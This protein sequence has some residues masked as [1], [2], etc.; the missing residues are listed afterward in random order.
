MEES[1]NSKECMTLPQRPPTLAMHDN[2]HAITKLKPKIRIVHIF[3][4][5]IIKTDPANF[6]ELVQRLT[7]KP[8]K[9]TAAKKK[10]I[11]V[12]INGEALPRCKRFEVVGSQQENENSGG[13][14]GV[15]RELE[16]E[17]EVVE[18]ELRVENNTG[19]F[20]HDLGEIDSFL[21]GLS[22]LPLPPLSSSPMDTIGEG[23][24]PEII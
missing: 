10:T 1:T 5:E 6:R 18:K 17:V 24:V 13:R 12:T 20:F 21:Q 9:R 7:G 22:D 14:D 15:K 11:P 19:G 8:T 23:T 4:P 2:S 3:A 16:E